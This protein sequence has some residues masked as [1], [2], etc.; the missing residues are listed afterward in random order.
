MTAAEA[1]GTASDGTLERYRTAERALWAA[2]G[3][4]PREHLVEVPE[5]RCRI[6]VL[7]VGSG[8]PVVFVPGTGGI[9]PYW[10]PLAQRL[11]GFR[12]LLVDRP[13]WGPSDPIDYRG[14]ALADVSATVLGAVQAALD[15][16]TVDVIGASVGN[17][18]G[19]GLAARRPSAVRR[20]VLLGGGPWREVPIP[21][22]FRV[23]ASPLGAII[24]RLPL[25]EAATTSQIRAL[26]HGPSLDAGKLDQFIAWRVS[27]TRET[28]SMRHER[29]MVQ[30]YLGGRAWRSGFLP[31]DAELASV[32][33]PV[34]MLFG[35]EDPTGTP[36]IWER[37]VALL[38]N[39]S[40]QL[41]D[42]AGHMVWWD[43]AE[44]V[45]GSVREFLEAGA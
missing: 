6:R 32:R 4:E 16:P 13:G 37:F 12:C 43:D 8:P 21:T 36:A 25:S 20:I 5:L 26:G 30:A 19:L 44:G 22:F 35:T 24:V 10:A 45:G 3:L 9:G 34:R 33:H 18:W 28:P 31:T 7:E 27:L 40:L 11:S 41:V 42:G 23:L 14:H 39:A 29:A 15:A 17:L 1:V 2:F 38:S